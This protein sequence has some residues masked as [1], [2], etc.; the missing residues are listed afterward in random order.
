MKIR[1]AK[2]EDFNEIYKI[3][4]KTKELQVS[5]DEPFMDKEDLKLRIKNKKHIFLL[6]E[7]KNKI[8]GF[9]LA[10]IEDTDRPLKNK[11]ACMIYLA[12]TPEFRR[13]GMATIL[14]K[15]L[16][17]KLKSMQITHVY[18]WANTESD[19]SIIKF[20]ENQKFKRGHQYL[21]MDKKL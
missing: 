3:G 7:D 20:M 13:K 19:G 17:A 1:K 8:M 21:W 9:I 10:N 2:I 16:E 6:A 12:I 4:L 5:S 15:E 11:Y 14:Y 18:G